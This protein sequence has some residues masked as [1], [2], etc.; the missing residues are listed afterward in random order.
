VNIAII[1]SGISGLSSAWYASKA[2]HQVS[3]F[4]KDVHFGGHAI[5]MSIPF[6]GTKVAVN[7]GYDLCNKVVYPKYVNLLEELGLD[8]QPCEFSYSYRNLEDCESENERTKTLPAFQ[9][10]ANLLQF[11]RPDFLRLAL[12][13]FKLSKKIDQFVAE[14]NKKT[15]SFYT[16][17][18]GAN[19]PQDLI[20]SFFIPV[21]A[22]PWGVKAEDMRD[23]P[24]TVILDW[25]NK[26]QILTP[27]PSQM[28]KNTGG[29]RHYVDTFV[30]SLKEHGVSLQRRAEV[31]KIIRVNNQIHILFSDGKVKEFDGV[32]IAS[33]AKIAMNLLDKP[34]ADEKRILS[35]FR[36]QNNNVLVHSDE[37]VM[38]K[39]KNKWRYFNIV[40]NPANHETFSTMWFGIDKDLPVFSTNSR[41]MP[42]KP[43]KIHA[44]FSFEQP[45]FD[46]NTVLAQSLLAGIQGNNNTWFSGVYCQGHGH[47]ESGVESGHRVAKS[48]DARSKVRSAEKREMSVEEVCVS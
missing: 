42:F 48:I 7:P 13:T 8:I 37:R 6:K 44:E 34:T 22:R 27:R 1:G 26:L 20:D 46:Q 11:L 35:L 17:L 43:E 36:Y 30:A 21:C 41:E 31:S 32:V 10:P 19:I 39:D 9:K 12:T 18:Q 14:P 25:I 33:N 16:F 2:G 3:V 38:P 15:I 5:E 24:V 47:H 40:Y 4:E 45:I 23:M 29:V 28:Y